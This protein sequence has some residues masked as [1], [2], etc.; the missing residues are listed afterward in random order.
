MCSRATSGVYVITIV[1]FRLNLNYYFYKNVCLSGH[2]YLSD[3]F[4]RKKVAEAKV[5]Y[6]YTQLSDMLKG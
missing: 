4:A 1:E 5:T 3:E 6:L 2:L